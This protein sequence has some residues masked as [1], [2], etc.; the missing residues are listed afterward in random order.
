M[1]TQFWLTQAFNGISYGALLFLVGSGLS[2]IFGVMRIVNL[3]HGS[4]FLLG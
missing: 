1:N 2:L 3:S 4:Y